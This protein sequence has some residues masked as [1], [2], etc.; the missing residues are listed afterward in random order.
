[1]PGSFIP[2][3]ER[4][5]LMGAVDLHI[6]GTLLRYLA[7]LPPAV[8]RPDRASFAVN[9]S[10]S[11][12]GSPDMLQTLRDTLQ[13]S[14]VPPA[15]LVFEITETAA[16]A[17]LEDSV[18]WMKSLRDLGCRFSLDDFGSGLSS[19]AY[20]KNLPIDYL[21]IDGSFI[22]PMDQDALSRA[23]VESINDI[24]HQMGLRTIAE[25]VE[26]DSILEAVRAAGLDFAQG[27]K[28]GRARPL[29]ELGSMLELP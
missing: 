17:H 3:A 5:Q 24:G 7:T 10:G 20:L 4:Y 15:C 18:R 19:Y 2:A 29:A 1:M 12:L 13:R 25:H 27:Y 11:S 21:K 16:I 8:L 14:G 28:I 23:I 22:R 26:T 6:I 9:L